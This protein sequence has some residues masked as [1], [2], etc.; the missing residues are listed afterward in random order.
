MDVSENLK[1]A[2]SD[3]EAA[4]LPEHVQAIALAE[5]LRMRFGGGQSVEEKAAG[6]TRTNQSPTKPKVSASGDATG[7]SGAAVDADSFFAAVERETGVSADTLETIFFLKDGVPCIN[8]PRRMLGQSLKQSQ[9]IV[10]TL[11]T[12]AR[13]FGLGEAEVPGLAVRA[14]CQRLNV[15]D[16]NFA[17]NVKGIAGILQTG[18]RTKVFKIRAAAIDTFAS[19][20]AVVSGEAG[21]A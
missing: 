15:F 1:K 2:W 19:S 6:P 17:S 10:T 12:V 21:Q 13:H 3:V 16:R 11:I 18:D 8:A 14:E 7:D 20:V 9:V 4:S 5:A